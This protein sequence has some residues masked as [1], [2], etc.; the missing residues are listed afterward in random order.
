MRAAAVVTNRWHGRRP[1]MPTW[2][3]DAVE[4]LVRGAPEERAAGAILRDALVRWP[5]YRAEE[6][7]LSS[8]AVRS[9]GVPIVAVPELVAEVQDLRGLGRVAAHLFGSVRGRRRGQPTRVRP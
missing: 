4:R 2:M 1:P 5:R 7:A 9:G 8:F 3:P 6:L